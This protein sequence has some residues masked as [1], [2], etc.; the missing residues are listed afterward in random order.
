MIS[1]EVKKNCK[2]QCLWFFWPFEI[3]K[4]SYIVLEMSQVVKKYPLLALKLNMESM[5]FPIITY[6]KIASIL[7]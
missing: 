2:H 6:Y 5:T 3:D 1:M 7:L 4:F